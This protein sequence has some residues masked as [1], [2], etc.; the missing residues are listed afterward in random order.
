MYSGIGIN[1]RSNEQSNVFKL[2]FLSTLKY[3]LITNLFSIYSSKSWWMTQNI[4]LWLVKTLKLEFFR[5]RRTYW[6]KKKQNDELIRSKKFLECSFWT[7]YQSLQIRLLDRLLIPMYTCT[8]LQQL[9][10]KQM[11]KENFLNDRFWPCFF[12]RIF[13]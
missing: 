2:F 8:M 4:K 6:I 11:K 10:K 7:V 3:G 13:F 5:S 9:Y 1:K 12:F